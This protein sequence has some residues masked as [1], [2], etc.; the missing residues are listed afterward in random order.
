MAE[1]GTKTAIFTQ[2]LLGGTLP[3]LFYPKQ[4]KTGNLKVLV[5]DSFS[6]AIDTTPSVDRLKIRNF[7]FMSKTLL[8]CTL[9]PRLYDDHPDS[10]STGVC[11][12]R[13]VRLQVST[14]DVNLDEATRATSP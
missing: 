14:D 12:T 11:K 8:I 2:V 6:A 9:P 7:E 3:L 1:Q 5:A 4:G 10:A 13:Y